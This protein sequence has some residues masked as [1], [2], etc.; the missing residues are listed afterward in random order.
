VICTNR[1]VADYEDD[2]KA[3]FRLGAVSGMLDDYEDLVSDS[4]PAARRLIDFLD[5]DWDDAVLTY[6][7]NRHHATTPS[8]QDVV[9]PIFSRAMGCWRYYRRELQPVLG[10]LNRFVHEFGYEE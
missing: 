4:K 2:G 6:Y 3:W 8:Y 10:R 1:S 5:L 7:K 9:S